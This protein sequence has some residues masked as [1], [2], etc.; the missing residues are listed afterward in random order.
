MPEIVAPENASAERVGP[1]AGGGR[2]GTEADRPLPTRPE[3]QW[4]EST[5]TGTHSSGRLKRGVLLPAQGPGWLTWDPILRHSPNRAWRRWG[6]DRLLRTTLRVLREFRRTHPKAP[7]IAVGDLSRP[8]GGDFGPQFGSIGHASHQNGLDIDVYYPRRD[9]RLQPPD[10]ADQVNLRLAQSLV[11]GFVAAGA[12]KVFV[13]PA[14]GLTGP[15]DVVVPLVNHD[16]HLHARL[17][18]DS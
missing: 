17:P 8:E 18:L 13:G 1:V 6:S 5:S 4:R 10:S 16:N 14:L 7:R 3:V 15:G 2:T 11:D 12:E 9:R